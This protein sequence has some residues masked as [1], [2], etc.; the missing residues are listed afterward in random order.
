[1]IYLLQK[2]IEPWTYQLVKH[3]THSLFTCHSY[4]SPGALCGTANPSKHSFLRPRPAAASQAVR[5]RSDRIACPAVVLLPERDSIPPQKGPHI[6]P[7]PD[8]RTQSILPRAGRPKLLSGQSRHHFSRCHTVPNMMKKRSSWFQGCICR[9][10]SAGSPLQ[11]NHTSTLSR[12]HR[13]RSSHRTRCAHQLRAAAVLPC[14]CL[15]S[16]AKRLSHTVTGTHVEMDRLLEKGRP[17]MPVR[18]GQ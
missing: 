5:I 17:D 8:Y 2:P 9:L 7:H 18:A 6:R 14:E 15:Y 13:K 4:Q 12:S 3:A 11:P 16:G 1:M 10:C